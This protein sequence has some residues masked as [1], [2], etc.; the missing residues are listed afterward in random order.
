MLLFCLQ[1]ILWKASL[2]KT[3]QKTMVPTC[4]KFW[5]KMMNFYQSV[6]PFFLYFLFCVSGSVFRIWIHKVAATTLAETHS[7]AELIRKSSFFLSSQ[8]NCRHNSI[9]ICPRIWSCPIY[10]PLN[11]NWKNCRIFLHLTWLML[12]MGVCPVCLMQT[13]LPQALSTRAAVTRPA[14]AVP[15]APA[16]G[17]RT[18]APATGPTRSCRTAW[19]PLTS[20]TSSP[21]PATHS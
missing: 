17:G 3:L 18:A 10:C 16:T 21:V 8:K 13:V 11:S 5:I 15:A 14:G 1:F 9:H 6:Q 2:D 7:F 12:G 19:P 4:R 20:G